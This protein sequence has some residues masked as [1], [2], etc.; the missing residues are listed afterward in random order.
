MASHELRPFNQGPGLS[1][2]PMQELPLAD[3]N[4]SDQQNAI[5]AV[6]AN[7][8]QGGREINRRALYVGG[9]DQ[10]V[11]EDMLSELFKVTGS[12]SSIKIFPDKNVGFSI[13]S[14][15]LS[16]LTRLFSGE[17]SIMHLSS[18]KTITQQNWLLPH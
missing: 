14:G 5:S 11:T 6:P 18:T 12:V 2:Q 16:R 4:T 10:N 7:A 3:T 8:S 13:F 15:R 17:D 1:D 9:V